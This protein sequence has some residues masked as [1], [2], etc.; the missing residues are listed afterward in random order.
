MIS[1]AAYQKRMIK[2]GESMM[3]LE[4]TLERL[5]D[6]DILV[7]GVSVKF[8]NAEGEDYFMT[9]RAQVEGELRVA[10]HGAATFAESVE[11]FVN[12]LQRGQLRWKV[13]KYA[14]N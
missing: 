7:L 13:D 1:V 14:G 6:K 3:R 12:R 9:V 8:P 2:L 5:Y 4:A 11:G 10:F